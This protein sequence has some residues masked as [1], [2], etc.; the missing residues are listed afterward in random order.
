MISQGLAISF[1]NSIPESDTLFR[2]PS[3]FL[4]RSGRH[5]T[6]YIF[7]TFR[8]F[9]GEKPIVVGLFELHDFLKIR[10]IERA[11]L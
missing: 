4:T 9:Y 10:N 8:F 11:G 1:E 3:W 6:Y 5:Q 2:D 7:T